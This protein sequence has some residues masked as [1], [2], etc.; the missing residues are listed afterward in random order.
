MGFR[1]RVHAIDGSGGDVHGSVKSKGEIGSGEIVVDGLGDADYMDAVLKQLLR[2]RK[3]V[4]ATDGDQ[5]VATLLLQIF[6]AILQAVAAF[7]WIGT[8]GSQDRAA[9]RKDSAHG[10]K[11]ERHGFAF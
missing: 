5:S 7:G 11:I 9:A 6:G 1:G 2:D 4:V 10:L 3:R 8:R